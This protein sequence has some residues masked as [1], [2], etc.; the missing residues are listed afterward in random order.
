MTESTRK[1]LLLLSVETP[2]NRQNHNQN[3]ER[4]QKW[5]YDYALGWPHFFY[6]ETAVQDFQNLTIQFERKYIFFR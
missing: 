2:V 4:A 1:E 5:A 6:M 3:Q